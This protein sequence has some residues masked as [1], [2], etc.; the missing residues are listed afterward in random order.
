MERWWTQLRAQLAADPKK[1]AILGVLC[2][3]LALVWVRV[4]MRPG[5]VGATELA[6][7]SVSPDLMAPNAEA[8]PSP[9]VAVGGRAGLMAPATEVQTSLIVPTVDISGVPRELP[10]DPFEL[11]RE[12]LGTAVLTS[13]PTAQESSWS[14]L[15][16]AFRE[17][18]RARRKIHARR[19]HQ[20]ESDAAKLKL[21]STLVGPAPTAVINGLIVQ[22]GDTIDGFVIDAIEP[23][24][25]RVRKDGHTVSLSLP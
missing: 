5:R 8:A 24:L 19:M 25:V 18:A 23:R 14:E 11:D 10:R 4:F 6:S 2:V 12:W 16:D 20:I 17:S 15:W 21:Q 3:V 13:Q 22:P 9:A 1:A 7:A